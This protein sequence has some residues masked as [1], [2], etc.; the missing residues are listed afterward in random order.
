M[1]RRGSQNKPPAQTP[2]CVDLAD[3]LARHSEEMIRCP[4]QPGN[5]K[6]LPQACAKRHEIANQPRWMNIG[7][8]SLAVYLFKANLIPCRQCGIGASCAAPQKGRAA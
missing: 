2:A 3:W 5:L 7:G 1:R 6:L 4:N 8:D